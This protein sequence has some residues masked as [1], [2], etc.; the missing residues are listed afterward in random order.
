MRG[1]AAAALAIVLAAPGARADAASDAL[2]VEAGACV[3][4]ASLAARV[5][6]WLR[7]GQV[8]PRVRVDVTAAP[9]HKEVRFVV[10]RGEAIVGKRTM[11]AD[12][13]TCSEFEAAVALA[14]A[15]SLEAVVTPA[16][17]ATPPVVAPPDGVEETGLAPDLP[18]PRV[19][20]RA[21][22]RRPPVAV[23]LGVELGAAAG[24]LLAP[25]SLVSPS[26][27]LHALD[28]FDLR[29]AF[30]FSADQTRALGPG[31]VT[32]QTAFGTLSACYVVLPTL[33]RLRGCAGF[34]VGGTGGRAAGFVTNGS[35]V[36]PWGGL[37]LGLDARWPASTP[38]AMVV[39]LRADV[40]AVPPT[41]TVEAVGS[42][43][44]NPVAAGGFVGL[45]VVAP[46]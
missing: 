30:A 43:R 19:E 25:A 42:A 33:V 5:S 3:E 36:A 34:S 2:R 31:L 23:A 44:T 37:A 27:E 46:R 4:P 22:T 24:Y 29:L 40:V 13:L 45:Q 7:G 6:M 39:G 14:I 12:E 15:S 38:I 11:R 21:A 16:A 8:D 41:F 1:I 10:R 20:R 32:L 26:V 18:P 35:A 9:D 17:P 28:R